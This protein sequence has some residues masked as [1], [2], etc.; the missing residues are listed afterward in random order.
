MVPGV[1]NSSVKHVTSKKESND[2]EKTAEDTKLTG[3]SNFYFDYENNYALTGYHKVI[4]SKLTDILTANLTAK[5]E[6]IFSFD[7]DSSFRLSSMNKQNSLCMG[8]VEVYGNADEDIPEEMQQPSYV[9][10]NVIKKSALS[11]VLS[12]S[13]GNSSF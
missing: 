9:D 13:D 1:S 6:N 11:A 10:V 12:S 4:T 8:Q 7:D 5:V 2:K 3:Y